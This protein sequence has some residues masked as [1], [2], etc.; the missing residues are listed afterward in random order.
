METTTATERTIS[1]GNL[2]GSARVALV[3]PAF[4]EEKNIAQVVEKAKHFAEW[5]VVIDDGSRDATWAICQSFSGNV[6]PLRHRVNLGKG[7]AL[8]TGCL[9]AR[10]LGAEVIVTID[11][12]G[13]HPPEIIPKVLQYMTDN[14]LDVVFTIRKGGQKMPLVRWLGNRTLNTM[15]RYLFHLNLQDIWCGF[16][17]LKTKCLDLID[18]DSCDYA[19]EIQMALKVGRQG[20]PYGEYVI[21]TIY[22]D[23]FKGVH[24][25][26]GL[27]VL[28]QMIIWRVK[29]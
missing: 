2:S 15:A 26:H 17:A 6:V 13:Q 22:E 19:G 25:L 1:R 23:N 20:L 9:A 27:K 16:R 14:N 5:V 7:A 12:D 18:W 29:L 28:G 8:K 24:I 10:R 11:G 4:N 21:P 3:V